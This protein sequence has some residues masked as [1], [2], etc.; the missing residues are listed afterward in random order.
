MASYPPPTENL[1]IFDDIVF[2]DLGDEPLTFNDAKKYFLQ[3]PNA[4][5]TENLQAINVNDVATFYDDIGAKGSLNRFG[6][7]DLVAN[8]TYLTIN[9]TTQTITGNADTEINLTTTGL[10]KIGDYT[11][12]TTYMFMDIANQNIDL[13]SATGGVALTSPSVISINALPNGEITLFTA[14]DIRIGNIGGAGNQNELKINAT[15]MTAKTTNGFQ[16][17]D[18]SIQYPSSYRTTS[19]TLATTFQYAQTFNGSSITATLPLVDSN[20]VGTQYLITNTNATALTVASSGSQTIYSTISPATATSRSLNT[21]H[22]HIFTAIRTT[23]TNVYGWSM[24]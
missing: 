10:V 2:R 23:A 24:V 15:K 17:I 3:F 6:D 8:Q 19:T 7:Y 9:D 12:A 20:N 18:S 21:G 14:G 22:S 11:G 5:G 16:L 13:Y 1:P 4:Q